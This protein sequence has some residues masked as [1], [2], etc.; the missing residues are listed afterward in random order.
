MCIQI[1]KAHNNRPYDVIT[2]HIRNAFD[3]TLVNLTQRSKVPLTWMIPYHVSN[4]VQYA[5][6]HQPC[7]VPSW[8]NGCLKSASLTRIVRAHTGAKC[9]H[10]FGQFNEF[11]DMHVL[12]Y[13]IMLFT[14]DSYSYML[15]G[16]V[17]QS[18]QT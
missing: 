5:A 12:L 13:K 6:M 1:A 4:R 14:P 2:A 9:L 17:G 7:M 15:W 3:H 18:S 16:E 8:L 10:H 11:L